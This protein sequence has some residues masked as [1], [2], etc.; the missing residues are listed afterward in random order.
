MKFAAIVVL[1]V[2]VTG[3]PA[4]DVFST[5]LSQKLLFLTHF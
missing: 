5:R 2:A 4:F 1:A 3:M